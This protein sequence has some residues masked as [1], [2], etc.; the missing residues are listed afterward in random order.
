MGETLLRAFAVN[1][2]PVAKRPSTPSMFRQVCRLTLALLGSCLAANT[3]IESQPGAL[4]ADDNSSDTSVTVELVFPTSAPLSAATWM[5]SQPTW[6]PTTTTAP[7]DLAVRL[8]QDKPIADKRKYQHAVLPN[9]I[10]VVNIEDAR[11]LQ[12]AA[13]V[14]VMAGSYHNPEDLPGLAHFCEHMLFLGSKKYPV[15]NSFN[16]FMNRHAAWHNAYTDTEITNYF[17]QLAQEGVEEGLD[18]LANFFKSPLFDEKYVQSEVNAVDSEHSKNIDN[19]TWFTL[20]A[21]SAL[22]NPASPV[23]RF[24]TGNRK[25]LLEEPQAKGI[26]TVESLRTYFNTEYCSPRMKVVTIG[27]DSLE[28][29]L[30]RSI[31]M[32]SD[33]G[34]EDPNCRQSAK[35]FETPPAWPDE[36]MGKWQ[37]ILGNQPSASLWL[38]FALEDLTSSFKSS[39]MDYVGHVLS[40][41]GVDSFYLLMQD[42]LGLITDVS[43]MLDSTSAGSNFYVKFDL[44]ALGE[45]H[46][47]LVLDLFYLYLAA[48]RQAGVDT[49]LYESLAAVSKLMWNWTQPGDPGSTASGLTATLTKFPAESILWAEQRIDEVNASL[50]DNALSQMVPS[51]MNVAFVSRDNDTSMFDGLVVQELPHYGRQYTVQNLSA[52]LP[53]KPVQWNQWLS[54]NVTEELNQTLA[55]LITAVNLSSASLSMPLLPRAIEGIPQ[56]IPMD[57]MTAT[58]SVG[59]ETTVVANL[60]G[61][62]PVVLDNLQRGIANSSRGQAYYSYRPGWV[63][64]SPKAFIKIALR[65]RKLPSEAPASAID[66][67]R[68]GIYTSLLMEDMAPKMVDLEAA[69]SSSNLDLSTDAIIITLGGFAPML[70]QLAHKTLEE[71]RMFEA[72]PEVNSVRFERLVQERHQGLHAYTGNLVEYAVTARNLMIQDGTYSRAELLAA[73]QNVTAENVKSAAHDLLFSK[74]LSVSVLAMGNLPESAAQEMIGIAVDSLLNVSASADVPEVAEVQLMDHIVDVKNPIEV[75]MVNPKPGDQNDAL[76]LS[77]IHGVVDVHSRVVYGLLGSI[78]GNL[79]FNELRTERQLGYIVDGGMSVLGNALYVSV[80]VQGTKERA[81]QTEVLSELLYQKLMPEMLANMTE[82]DFQAHR[83]SFRDGLVA[84]PTSITEEFGH[85]WSPTLMNGACNSLTDEMLTYLDIAVNEKQVIIDA[86]EQLLAGENGVRKK[87]VVKYFAGS[88]PTRPTAIEVQERLAK[89]GIA[90]EQIALVLDE[91]RRTLVFDDANSTSRRQLVE[92]FGIM[93]E[94]LRCTSTLSLNATKNETVLVKASENETQDVSLLQDAHRYQRTSM[95]GFRQV[96]LDREMA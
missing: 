46:K 69:G 1:P 10:E 29:Q 72:Q 20:D 40:Y 78:L 28:V 17:L 45:K 84:P 82:E 23:S 4:Q 16:D 57:Y 80:I 22:A 60:F 5:P 75:R 35:T 70:A 95:R 58:P 81:D 34:S 77:M 76:V 14:A 43:S 12:A 96:S 90:E 79:A 61:S 50:V 15:A 67:L 87:V 33:A 51:R 3:G 31:K 62:A 73:L 56:D 30:N 19:P 42:K 6:R 52:V 25:T 32:F 48:I 54:S 88:V 41:R 83:S 86:W 66:R 64:F 7:A 27:S 65:V 93:P 55:E 2:Y 8:L 36:R 37:N 38:L 74:P 9:G 24:S 26:D 11:T 13:A 21:M 91:Y 39:P 92:E 18:R 44:T 85:F 47:D 89:E 94:D 59:S 68:L 63:T 71:L 53:G 49:A